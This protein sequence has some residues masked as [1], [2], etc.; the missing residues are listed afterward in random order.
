MIR[1]ATFDDMVRLDQIAREF[2][3]LH[4]LATL[5]VAFDGEAISRQ[6]RAMI[7]AGG[8]FIGDKGAIG[9]MLSPVW[10]APGSTVAL[11]L[12][13][14]GQGE[15][16]ALKRRF[17]QWAKESG[18]FAFVMSTLGREWDERTA[19]ILSKDGYEKSEQVWMKVV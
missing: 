5:G 4:P 12:F 3:A 14:Y 16:L 11:E 19:R 8:V 2:F 7:D 1:Q 13:W 10:F 9:G 17:E 6:V 18:A 15:G